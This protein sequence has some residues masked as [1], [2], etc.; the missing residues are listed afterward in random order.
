VRIAAVVVVA[1]AAAAAT[2]AGAGAFVHDMVD[3]VV[4]A[5][6]DEGQPVDVRPGHRVL[7]AKR[8]GERRRVRAERAGGLA[9]CVP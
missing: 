7:S 9:G 1:T 5:D 8:G 2:G 4:V 6:R 3:V